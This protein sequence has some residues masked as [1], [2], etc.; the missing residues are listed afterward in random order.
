MRRALA[1]SLTLLVLTAAPVDAVRL[2]G[3]TI[4]LPVIGRFPGDG[5]TQWQTDVFILNGYGDT[6]TVTLKFYDGGTLREH[7]AV[8]QPYHSLSLP[9]VVLA[10]YGRTNGGGPLEIESTGRI[11][12]RARIYN[13]GN[14]A[15]QFGQS[16]TGIGK[17][18]LSRQASLYGLSGIGTRVN[19]GAMNPHDHAVTVSMSI[20]DRQN[21]SLGGTSFELAPHT[22]RQFSNIFATFGIPEQDGV[23]VQFNEFDDPIYGYASEV[24]NDTGDA[25]FTFGTAPNTGP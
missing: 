2:E 9:D 24:R 7:S 3:E 8:L 16:V 20:T 23:R 22:Y 25:V 17:D 19:V 18:R 4:I 11:E 14:P 6:V 15:G 10:T 1:A 12:A 5:G 13:T 21:Q